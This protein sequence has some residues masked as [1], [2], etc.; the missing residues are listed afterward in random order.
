MLRF[1]DFSTAR[2]VKE[3]YFMKL[4][5]MFVQPSFNESRATKETLDPGLHP[6]KI[7]VSESV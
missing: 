2:M 1:D 3:E 6:T 7:G 4:F 5:H